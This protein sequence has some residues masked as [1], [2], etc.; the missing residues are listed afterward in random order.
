MKK[1]RPI[2]PGLRWAVL[3][4]NHEL[5]REGRQTVEPHKPL[6]RIKR[7]T[8]G[9][10]NN[11][12]ITCRHRGGGAKR[13]Y[14]IVDFKRDKDN[15]PAKVASVEYDPNRTAHIAL[16]HYADGDKRYILAAEGLK[17]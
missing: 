11:G 14:R 10:N 17:R 8:N 9:R 4:S 6:L 5:T 13:F 12:H 16:L 2:T 7:R 15:V 3:P 1:F